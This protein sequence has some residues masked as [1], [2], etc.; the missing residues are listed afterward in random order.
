MIDLLIFLSTNYQP[1][2][3]QV[4]GAE[5]KTY[6]TMNDKED[7]IATCKH[8]GS[9]ALGASHDDPFSLSEGMFEE[10]WQ[11]QLRIKNILNSSVFRLILKNYS[12]RI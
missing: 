11:L 2:A 9:W 12:Y 3:H 10:F 4:M 1:L 8:M 7:R 5:K 6:V